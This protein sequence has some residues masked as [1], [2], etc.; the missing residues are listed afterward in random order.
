MSKYDQDYFFVVKDNRDERLPELAATDST[1][2][3]QY[4]HQRQP[5]GSAPL[6]FTNGWREDNLENKVKD[7]LADIL[8]DGADLMVRS[9]IRERLLNYEIPNLAIHPAVYIDD[10]EVWHEDYWYLTGA[11]QGSCRVKQF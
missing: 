4:Q 9:H 6:I 7:T 3:R 1:E 11:C 10:R 8:F 2:N 5:V